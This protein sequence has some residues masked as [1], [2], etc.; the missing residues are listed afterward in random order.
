MDTYLLSRHVARYQALSV[1]EAL[2]LSRTIS[3]NRASCARIIITGV[4]K[5]ETE[6]ATYIPRYPLCLLRTC[7]HNKNLAFPIPYLGLRSDRPT[8]GHDANSDRGCSYRCARTSRFIGP[9]W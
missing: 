1:L 8:P 3:D 6:A 7:K 2:A 9:S 4:S 5:G